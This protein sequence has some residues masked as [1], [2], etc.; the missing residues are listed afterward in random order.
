MTINA[1][2]FI[3][4]AN[5]ALDRGE[6]TKEVY[7]VLLKDMPEILDNIFENGD[8]TGDLVI[9]RGRNSHI[10]SHIRTENYITVL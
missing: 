1:A 2:D 6:I 4:K 3:T 5:E 9:G 10:G 7:N 8:D